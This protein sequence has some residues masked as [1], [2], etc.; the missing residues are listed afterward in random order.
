MNTH[1]DM[2]K[3]ASF[4]ALPNKKLNERLQ[5][6]LL[7][8]DGR[9]EESIPLVMADPSQSKAYYRFV[10][11][12][13]VEILALLAANRRMVLE[14]ALPHGIILAVQ[15]ST[16]LDLT[17]KRSAKALGCLSYAH[18]KGLYLHNH[19]LLT[20]QGEALGLFD[21]QFFERDPGQLGKSRQNR[22]QPFEQKESFRW[23]E[24][25]NLLQQAFQDQ[26]DKQVIQICDREA[27]IHELLQ[28]RTTA[29]VHYIIRSRHDRR[30]QPLNT[31]Q[32]QVDA[33]VEQ[34]PAGEPSQHEESSERI[35]QQLSTQ[36]SQF[37]Y[38]LLVDHPQHGQR[39]AHLQVRYCQVLIQPGY[40][41]KQQTQLEPLT[42]WLVET[43]EVNPPDGVEALCWRL[44][45]SLPV[46]DELEARRLISYYTYR[47]CIERFHFV[48]KQ[49][50]RV[51]KLQLQQVEPLKKAIILYSW[52]ALKVL[53]TQHLLQN[54][55]QAPISSI[56]IS[57]LDYLIVYQYLNSKA[58]LKSKAT[59]LPPKSP[60]PTLS[61]W[62]ALLALTLG[63]KLSKDGSIGV[64][65][66]WRA[67]HK[68]LLIREAYFA[69]KD[70]GNR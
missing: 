35:Y 58:V 13:R 47:W 48:L 33:Q 49:G 39:L 27:D 61:E 46:A 40:R 52:I 70:V 7:Q 10:N 59:K 34:E 43:S 32:E 1:Q 3:T 53:Q 57:E 22:Y 2:A 55:P 44:L 6:I 69:F 4:A 8:L 16:P 15:D 60:Q 25:F 62:A 50:C 64:V 42:L 14:L 65:S 30:I 67:Y 20:E 5:R 23:L 56:A 45:T 18:Q 38:Q 11:N 68:F 9:L 36:Q 66:L 31:Q 28:A 54:Q 17:G 19:L 37:S 21:Q 29:H 41:P 51:E 12:E 63:S 24:Q 26:P